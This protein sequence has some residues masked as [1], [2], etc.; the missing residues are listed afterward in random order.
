M[1]TDEDLLTAGVT[2]M[3][4]PPIKRNSSIYLLVGRESTTALSLV[5][6][7]SIESRTFLFSGRSRCPAG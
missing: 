5:F 4:R 7:I 6:A 3:A 2:I 1:L